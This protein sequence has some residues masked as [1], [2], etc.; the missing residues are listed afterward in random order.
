MSCWA[1][2]TMFGTSVLRVE[3][4]LTIRTQTVPPPYLTPSSNHHQIGHVPLCSHH[5]SFA[6]P[7]CDHRQSLKWNDFHRFTNLGATNR[8]FFRRLLR[9]MRRSG[10]IARRRFVRQTD[11]HSLLYDQRFPLDDSNSTNPEPFRGYKKPSSCP[12]DRLSGCNDVNTPTHQIR[13]V[14]AFECRKGLQHGT[15][16]LCERQPWTVSLEHCKPYARTL[17]EELQPC[18]RV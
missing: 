9:W 1:A 10:L 15:Y 11:A 3:V 2:A 6:A 17:T 4:G 5:F 7:S 18:A 8:S 13:R 12:S 16:S 14:V